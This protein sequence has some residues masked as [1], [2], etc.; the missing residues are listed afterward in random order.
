LSLIKLHV[1][2]RHVNS[3]STIEHLQFSC[4]VNHLDYLGV[5]VAW[6]AGPWFLSIYMNMLPWET[7]QPDVGL[8]EIVLLLFAKYIFSTPIFANLMRLHKGPK[9]CVVSSSCCIFFF[10][11]RPQARSLLLHTRKLLLLW[12]DSHTDLL[13]L[14]IHEVVT[15]LKMSLTHSRVATRSTCHTVD[16][17]FV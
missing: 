14:W 6:V 13:G 5:Q 16:R 1:P 11:T 17:V 12:L 4:A 3:S 9:L 2:V 15:L 10:E 8:F 7:G